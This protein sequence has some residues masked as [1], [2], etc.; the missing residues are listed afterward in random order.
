M[1]FKPSCSLRR[2]KTFNWVA[3][4]EHKLSYHNWYIYIYVCSNEHGFPNLVTDVK[5]LKSKPANF[6][7]TVL[8]LR[9]RP[10]VKGCC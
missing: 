8:D 6:R 3:V 7:R 1:V 9:V 4:K 10:L 5:F 2:Q